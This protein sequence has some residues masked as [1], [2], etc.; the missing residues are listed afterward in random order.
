MKLLCDVVVKL[1]VHEC[2]TAKKNI[3]KELGVDVS[4]LDELDNI[5]MYLYQAQNWGLV[6]R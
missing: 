5:E 6:E 1:K 2:K 4:I 3:K